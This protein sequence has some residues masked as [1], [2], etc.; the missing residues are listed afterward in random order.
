[1]GAVDTATGVI[2]QRID[3]DS[4]GNIILDTNPGFQPFAFAGGLYDPQTGLYHFGAREYDPTIGRWTTKDRSAL[5]VATPTSTPT[6][7]MIP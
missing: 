2:A 4:W 5:P 6:S 1:M 3:Y 7:P